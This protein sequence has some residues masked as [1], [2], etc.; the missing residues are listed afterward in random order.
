MK[1]II[2]GGFLGAGKTTVLLDLVPWLVQKKTGTGE[3][4]VVVLENEISMTDVD[5]RRLRDGGLTVR[6]LAA[7]CICCTSRGELL[8]SVEK[9]QREFQPE[10]LIIE[11]TGMAYPDSIKETVSDIPGVISAKIIAVADVCRWKKLLAAMTEFVKGQLCQADVVLMNKIDLAA[12]A[13]VEE[14]RKSIE[15]FTETA[16]LYAVSA[17]RGIPEYCFENLL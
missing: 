17:S 9:I 14:V 8:S 15:S 6:N 11:A 4:P 12:P 10:Y 7:G 13:V 5:A 2:L 1:V 3:Y 16:K